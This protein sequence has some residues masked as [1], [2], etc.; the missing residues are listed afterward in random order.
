MK[1]RKEVSFVIWPKIVVIYF[2]SRW[3]VTFSCFLFPLTSLSFRNNLEI[4]KKIQ[5]YNLLALIVLF[6]FLFF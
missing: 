3:R 5:S 1:G 6:L 2:N 4:V